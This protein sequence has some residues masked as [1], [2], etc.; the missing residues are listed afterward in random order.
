MSPCNSQLLDFGHQ[1]PMATDDTLEHAG[2]PQVVQPT[3]LPISLASG[4]HQREVARRGGLLEPAGQGH[5]NGLGKTDADEATR[6]HCVAIVN[7]LHG[8]IGRD[9]LA[10]VRVGVQAGVG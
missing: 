7:Q 6:G 1:P 9:E 2:L 8:F 5:G 4:I 3:V 10:A